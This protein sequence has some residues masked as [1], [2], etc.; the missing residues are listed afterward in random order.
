MNQRKLTISGL[1]LAKNEECRIARCLESV[2]WADERIVIDNGS[3]DKTV[4]LALKSGARVIHAPEKDFSRLRTLGK[5]EATGEWILYVDADE[6]ITPGLQAEIQKT[7]KEWKETSPVAYTVKRSNVYLG[8]P[9]PYSEHIP[10]LFRK[11]ALVGWH[12]E[13]HESPDVAGE[14]GHL[15]GTLLHN[16]HRTLEQM[17]EKTNQWSDVEAKLRRDAGHP[18]VVWWRLLRVMVT[19]FWRSYISQGGWRAG[20]VGLIESIYQGFSLFITYAKLWE[21]QQREKKL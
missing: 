2:A 14:T 13:L 11:R 10:R 20:A 1:I 17:L 12:G 3:T 5:E 15:H 4:S 6:S 9:W 18:P 7:V 8:S 16:T 21:L 19:G